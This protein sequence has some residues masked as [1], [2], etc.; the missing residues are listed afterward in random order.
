MVVG[1]GV[2]DGRGDVVGGCVYRCDGPGVGLALAVPA[3]PL[4]GVC[5]A[6]GLFCGD[7]E[8]T[9]TEPSRARPETSATAPAA[10]ATAI[11]AVTS[12]AILFTALTR[13]VRVTRAVDSDG[14]GVRGAVC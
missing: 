2:E 7:G 4:R 12:P 14:T 13:W 6:D 5:D 10:P 11:V 9:G 1:R 3:G 8:L